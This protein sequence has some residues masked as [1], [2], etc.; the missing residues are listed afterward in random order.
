MN[1]SSQTQGGGS[2]GKGCL[3]WITCF[4][5]KGRDAIQR[6]AS[7][8]PESASQHSLIFSWGL[9]RHIIPPLMS[10]ELFYYRHMPVDVFSNGFAL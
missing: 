5:G 7:K 4:P 10:S 8:R 6:L 3:T 1:Q 9:S 2:N